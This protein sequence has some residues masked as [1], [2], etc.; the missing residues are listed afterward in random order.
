MKKINFSTVRNFVIGVLLFILGLAIGQR[1]H[2]RISLV[3]TNVLQQNQDSA[4][5]KLTGTLIPPVEKQVNFDLFWEVWNLLETEY[6]DAQDLKTQD[7]VDG[8]I[9]GLTASTG[10]PYTMYLPPDDNKRSSED[11]QGSFYGVGIE[12]GYID[13]TLAVVAPLSG[14]PAE[15]AGIE[16]GDLI[17]RVRDDAKDIDED[18][19]Q[20]DLN[21]A[22][23]SIRGPKGT[24]V[25]LTLYRE[26]VAEPFEVSVK[27]DEIVVETVTLDILDF[28][29]KK[30]AHLKVAKFGARTTQEWDEAVR[31]ILVT[32]PPVAGIALDLRNNPGGFFDAAIDLASDFIEN[33]VVVSQKSRLT[34]EDYRSN[35]VARL[36]NYHTV[37]LVNKGSASASEIL[38]GALRDDVGIKLIGGQTF[39]KGTVQEIKELSNAGGVHIT[40]G[41]WLLPSGEWI[42]N[43]GIP[44]DIEVE[45][46][47]DTQ[48]DEVLQRALLELA[49]R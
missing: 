30:I 12:L 27:R 49:G 29:D 1:Y 7:M 40:I 13:Q 21:K 14:T 46:N 4:L 20:W 39:G 26:E 19:S 10:D 24:E 2:N 6:L 23:D 38:A 32:Q 18:S 36:K 3:S 28:Q 33:D 8:A 42:H 15:K 37:V 17:I 45:Q 9:K 22:L 35:G 43:E 25:V 34:Q 48:E 11:L 16:A 5:G 47:R 31:Q 44:V 41:R